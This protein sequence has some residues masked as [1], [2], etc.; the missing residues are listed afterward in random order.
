VEKTG[1]KVHWTWV[2][3]ASASVEALNV[4]D[5]CAHAAMECGPFFDTQCVLIMIPYLL[6]HYLLPFEHQLDLK[7]KLF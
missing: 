1:D 6:P 5:A 7:Q 2:N 4:A 3:G